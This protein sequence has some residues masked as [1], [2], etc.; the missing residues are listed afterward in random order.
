MSAAKCETGWGETLSTQALIEWRELH[1]T[2]PLCGDPPPPG[3]G[4]RHHTRF[5]VTET[6]GPFLMV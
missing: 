2:P 5:I 4:K 6:F 3:E 1:P